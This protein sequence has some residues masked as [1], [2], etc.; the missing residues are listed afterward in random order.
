VSKTIELTGLRF[1]RL[2]VGDFAGISKFGS[3]LWE[4]LCDCGTTKIISSASL[5]QGG[6][7]SCGC[8]MREGRPPKHGKTGSKVWKAWEAMLDRCHN[9][10]N[11]RFHDYGGRGIVVC[12][13]WLKFE[14][15]YEDMWDPAKGMSLDRLNND[16]NY[17]P[18]NCRWATAKTTGIE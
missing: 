12:Y 18:S 2:V 8:K 1:G 17:E 9:P 4:C 3:K 11:K 15:F 5:R 13:R 14:N 16:G 10:K 6:T 7:V